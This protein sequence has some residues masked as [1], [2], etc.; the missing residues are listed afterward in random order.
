MYAKTALPQSLEAKEAI[1]EL[2]AKFFAAFAADQNGR[3]DL[4][5]LYPLFINGASIIKGCGESATVYDLQGFI[6]PRQALLNG[7]DLFDFNEHE[8][9]ERTEI[10]GNIAQRFSLYHKSGIAHGERFEGQGI[11]AM[12]FSKTAEGWKIVSL[13]WNDESEALPISSVYRHGSW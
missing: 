13:I 7:P 4:A 3:V 5:A 6:A 9:F 12:Q 10:F 1:D 11:K 2:V 8:V